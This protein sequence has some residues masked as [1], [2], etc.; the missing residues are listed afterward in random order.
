M[1]P[2]QIPG[3]AGWPGIIIT[4][5]TLLSY[6][7]YTNRSVKKKVESAQKETEEKTED[8]A[9]KAKDDAINA[10]QLHLN[11]LKERVIETEK[12]NTRLNT[13]VNTI[14]SALEEMGMIVTIRGKMIL[15]KDNKGSSTTINISNKNEDTA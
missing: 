2:T 5:I 7:Y 15:I 13:I 8:I 10:M 12:E 6:G 3:L 11:I 9:K 1:D 14:T 4:V